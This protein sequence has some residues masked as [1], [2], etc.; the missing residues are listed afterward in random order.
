MIVVDASAMVEVI[1]GEARAEQLAAAMTSATRWCVPQHFLLEAAS[2]LRGSWLGGHLD[3]PE[4]VAA[5]DRLTRFRVVT[6]STAPLLS[7][8]VE[9]AANATPYD[10]AYVALAERLDAPLLTA[11]QKLSRIPGVRCRFLPE[12]T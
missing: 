4:F 12:A 10:A 1:T 8:I 11:D 7:R 5:V 6:W 2:G 9:L 3:R